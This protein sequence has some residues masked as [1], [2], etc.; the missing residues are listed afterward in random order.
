MMRFEGRTVVVTG[1]ASGIGRA[2]AIRFG[3]EGA[4][5]ACLDVNEAGAQE[6]A[7]TIAS[8][9]GRASAFGCDISDP[10]RV[11]A[12]TH[13]LIAELGDPHVL[14]NI[15]GVVAAH[16]LEDMAFG[17]WQRVIGVNLNGTFLMC[18]ALMPALKR[19]G[20]NIVNTGSRLGV[21][22]RA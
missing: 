2:T 15:A 22:G 1:A 5:V 19:T 8:S 4:H 13:R 11:R 3:S 21:Q 16:A 14:C 9:G 6:T 10:E 17:E 20:G 12:T 7:R 18:Q